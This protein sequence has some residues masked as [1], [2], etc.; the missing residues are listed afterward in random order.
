M[1]FVCFAFSWTNLSERVDTYETVGRRRKH[2]MYVTLRIAKTHAT[3]LLIA[4]REIMV[5]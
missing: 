5:V 4:E 1:S 2:E 3:H